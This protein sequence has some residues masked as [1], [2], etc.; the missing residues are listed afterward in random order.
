MNFSLTY[1]YN[2]LEYD[3]LSQ[4][5]DTEMEETYRD[6]LEIIEE[7]LR[8][9]QSDSI[10][11][12]FY[13]T[14]L[15]VRDLDNLD[16]IIL[17]AIIN[18]TRPD[19]PNYDIDIEFDTLVSKIFATPGYLEYELVLRRIIKYLNVNSVFLKHEDETVS[20]VKERDVSKLTDIQELFE[21]GAVSVLLCRLMPY[22]SSIISGDSVFLKISISEKYIDSLFNLH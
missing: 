11:K 3:Y 13:E 9:S 4:R 2:H 16:F 21:E 8:N 17:K 6:I 10:D 1:L 19:D 18:Q 22:F 12:N 15:S 14:P 7:K 5:G 20:Y